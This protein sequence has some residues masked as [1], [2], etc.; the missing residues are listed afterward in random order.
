[1]SADTEYESDP[2]HPEAGAS[3]GNLYLLE[4]CFL[5]FV[6]VVVLIAFS[7]ALSYKLVSSRTPFVIML[8]L[9]ILIV[10][11]GLRLWRIRESFDP[12]SLFARAMAGL[13]GSFNSVLGISGWMI[14]MVLMILVF[15]HYAGVFL[16]CVILMRMLAGEKWVLTLAVAA[17]TTFFIFGV[18]EYLFNIELYRGLIVR[19]FLGFRDF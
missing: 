8:P 10:I 7:Q 19:Y 16:F 12:K 15:G 6:G 3:G 5:V 17:G 11:H 13:N 1:M 4:I 14:G 9:G 18:F 2:K